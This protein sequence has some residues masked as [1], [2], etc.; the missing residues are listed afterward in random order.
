M[1]DQM[2][3]IITLRKVVA[4]KTAAKNIHA[5]IKQK[6]AEHPEVKIDCHTTDHFDIVEDLL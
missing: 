4:D 1:S 2:F 6:L 3:V 5:L